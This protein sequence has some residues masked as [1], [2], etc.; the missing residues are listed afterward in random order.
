MAETIESAG[1]RLKSA[2]AAAGLF[3]V[4]LL[5][6]KSLDFA[7]RYAYPEFKTTVDGVR[8]L[9]FGVFLVGYINQTVEILFTLAPWSR[10]ILH[11]AG[12]WLGAQLLDWLR[13]KKP[14]AP[15]A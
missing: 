9:V 5:I 1:T 12:A 2:L 11:V 15:K 7:L 8:L 13:S 3:L 10:A 14:N 6:H 4:L